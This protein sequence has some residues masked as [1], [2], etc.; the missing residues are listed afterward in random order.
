MTHRPNDFQITQVNL[1]RVRGTLRKQP[2]KTCPSPSFAYAHAGPQDI[3]NGGWLYAQG[4]D[5]YAWD[6]HRITQNHCGE[7]VQNQIQFGH[8]VPIDCKLN[9]KS[10]RKVEPNL[11]GDSKSMALRFVQNARIVSTGKRQEMV[12]Q[13][14]IMEWKIFWLPLPKILRNIL[15]KTLIRWEITVKCKFILTERRYGGFE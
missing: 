6:R 3:R 15:V 1:T 5:S 7:E 12:A 13:S 14:Q 9:A 2:K 11:A 8:Y 10:T 4:E